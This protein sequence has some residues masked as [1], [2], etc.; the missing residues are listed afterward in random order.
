MPNPTIAPYGAWKSPITSDL[1]VA[2]TISI[3]QPR[4]DGDALYWLELRPQDSGRVTLVRRGH[5]STQID[6]TPSPLNVRTRVHEYGGGA[7]TVSGG[8]AYFTDFRSQRLY[9]QRVGEEPQ[10]ITP[11]GEFRYADW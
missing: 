10:P 6:M 8:T 3:S 7:Y 9:G 11:E 5:N 4:M 2:D 1:I